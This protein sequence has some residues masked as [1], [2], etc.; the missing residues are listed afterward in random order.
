MI[1]AYQMMLPGEFAHSHWHSPHALR[2]ILEG[3]G[4]YTVVNGVRLDMHPGDVVLTPGGYWHWH[5]V[6]GDE[7]CSW[8]DVLDR[9]LTI[10]L[11]PVFQDYHPDGHEPV[12]ESATASPFLFPWQETLERAPNAPSPTPTGASGRGSSWATSRPPCRRLHSTCSD[13]KAVSPPR[14]IAV[15][16]TIFTA[17]LKALAVR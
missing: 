17:S 7:P 15:R 8:V 12:T 9:P 1:G 11:E 13:W 10:L 5:G 16:P 3:E 2:V 14:F 6:D 4:S